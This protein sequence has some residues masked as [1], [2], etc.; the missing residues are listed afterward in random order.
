MIVEEL[1]SRKDGLNHLL[2]SDV[3]NLL[4]SIQ[5]DFPDFTK[6]YS[7]G[8]SFEGREINAIELNKEGQGED[9]ALAEIAEAQI[10]AS[11]PQPVKKKEDDDEKEEAFKN[12]ELAQVESHDEE[13]KVQQPAAD[14]KVS[15]P[16]T[17]KT[18]AKHAILMT[19]ATHA[20]ELIST[21]FNIY[22]LLQLLQKGEVQPSDKWKKLLGMNKY[23]F[24]PIFNVDG[25]AYIEEQWVKTHK[26]AADRKNMD[27]K[28][29]ACSLGQVDM[30]VDINRNFGVDFGQVDDILQYQD[31]E[32][33][34]KKA[35]KKRG[36]DPCS[37]NY[38]GP[39]AFSEPETM[40]YKN[41][42]TSRK[43]EL[44]F[45]I[46]MHSNG[47]A[48]IYPFNGRQKNDIEERRPGILQI[49]T[50]ISEKAPF[51]QGTLK[52]TS[53]ETM[54]IA[55]GGDQDDWTLAELGVPS[56]TAEVGFVGQFIDEWR[57][58]DSGTATDIC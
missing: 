6:V 19:G 48:F 25:V 24:V 34:E 39:A 33:L 15:K 54:G 38:P 46:N 49:F 4:M 13:P 40:A 44:A 37:T 22:E 26:I 35:D 1:I 43:D 16:K 31:D 51:P 30:G 57:V 47:N 55:I 5:H 28:D 29:A 11:K 17:G 20:R 2:L 10:E 23:I 58:R 42:L 12:V 45:V 56:V 36:S 53:K 41:F 7:I 3:N 32:W 27:T 52:G 14:P 50:Q 18:V 8:S 21:T 9:D